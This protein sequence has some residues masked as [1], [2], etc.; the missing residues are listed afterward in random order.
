MIKFCL[1]VVLLA[2]IAFIVF[3]AGLQ[4]INDHMAQQEKI[5][6]EC[7]GAYCPLED[8]VDG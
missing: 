5:Y 6:Q 1:A 4:A 2:L 8:K 7:G 3:L